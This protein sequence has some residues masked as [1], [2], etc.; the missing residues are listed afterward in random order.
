MSI[1]QM[2]GSDRDLR[3]YVLSWIRSARQVWAVIISYITRTSRWATSPSQ[4]FAI[5]L[6]VV[7]VGFYDLVYGAF[8]ERPSPMCH[9]QE[10]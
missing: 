4:T 2:R 10:P 3:S 5:D 7:C 1:M 6:F 8:F 9:F